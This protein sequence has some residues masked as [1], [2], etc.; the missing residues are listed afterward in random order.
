VKALVLALVLTVAAPVAIAEPAD[1]RPV[2]TCA[3]WHRPAIRAGFT[4]RQWPTV[5][6]IMWRES[7]CH[8]DA[9]N[10][11]SGAA[12]LM[13]IMPMWINR[14]G[15]GNLHVPA[16]N[17]RCARLILRVQGWSAWR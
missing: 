10:R 2:T 3:Q 4:E 1:A 16:V 13:Q 15:G 11:R 9:H 5:V 14:C 17:L 12:G 8:P 6:R 7:R